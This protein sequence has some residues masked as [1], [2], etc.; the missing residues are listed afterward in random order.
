MRE[1]RRLKF[2]THKPH[3]PLFNI[4]N[5]LLTVLILQPNGASEYAPE[6]DVLSEDE[7]RLIGAHRDVHRIVHRLAQVHLRPL[8]AL[9]VVS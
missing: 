3:C 7:G 9:T 4:E 1:G 2:L 6:C 8:G 5:N